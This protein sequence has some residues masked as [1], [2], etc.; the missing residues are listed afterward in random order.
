MCDE[1]IDAVEAKT[2]RTNFNKK[3][4]SVKQNYSIFYFPFC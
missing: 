4:Q 3:M 2:V 1:I